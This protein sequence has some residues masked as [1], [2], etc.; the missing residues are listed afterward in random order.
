M[1]DFSLVSCFV[2]SAL[3]EDDQVGGRA[4]REGAG[5]LVDDAPG[6]NVTGLRLDGSEL[7]DQTDAAFG[8]NTV[9]RSSRCRAGP[10]Q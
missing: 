8:S 3:A 9:S 10:H 2:T 4:E 5:R 7:E 1:S 6:N